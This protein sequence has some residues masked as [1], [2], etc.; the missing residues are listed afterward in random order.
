VSSKGMKYK[1]P[2]KDFRPAPRPAP[3]VNLLLVLWI[4]RAQRPSASQQSRPPA[5]QPALE[6]WCSRRIAVASQ[7]PVEHRNG[8]TVARPLRLCPFDRSLD[9][10]T[11]ISSHPA[12][13]LQGLS[14]I[15]SLSLRQSLARSCF[16]RSRRILVLNRQQRACLLS[17]VPF[18]TLS[19]R[20]G[21]RWVVQQVL[22]TLYYI[23][24]IHVVIYRGRC[25]YS[26]SSDCFTSS[27]CVLYIMFV[28]RVWEI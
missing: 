2:T 14:I 17:F 4:R 15:G 21:N 13:G 19:A 9:R 1:N 26:L 11:P 18:V 12:A 24:R 20:P 8:N 3:Q 6:P 16:R 27:N 22:Y 10:L 7:S 28:N 5:N 23:K 25:H